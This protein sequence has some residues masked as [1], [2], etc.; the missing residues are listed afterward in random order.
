MNDPRLDDAKRKVE[1]AKAASMPFAT[2]YADPSKA[3]PT[4]PVGIWVKTNVQDPMLA[5]R[6]LADGIISMSDIVREAMASKVVM[7]DGSQPPREHLNGSN[8]EK[9]E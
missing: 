8:H 6:L 5:V 9:P 3:S 4:N 2:V 7:P 1:E